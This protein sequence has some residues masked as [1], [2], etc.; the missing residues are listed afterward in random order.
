VLDRKFRLLPLLLSLRVPLHFAYLLHAVTTHIEAS[1]SAKLSEPAECLSICCVRQFLLKSLLWSMAW[2]LLTL[3]HHDSGYQN[4]GAWLI[5]ACQI[6]DVEDTC[7]ISSGM[8]IIG[9]YEAHQEGAVL[10]RILPSR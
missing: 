7:D 9:M 4:R 8:V 3:T 6:F 5:F 2:S 10:I 1:E